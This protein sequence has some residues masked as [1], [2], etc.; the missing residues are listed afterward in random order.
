MDVFFSGQGREE[1]KFALRGGRMNKYEMASPWE[2]RLRK[3]PMLSS[4]E[5]QDCC[6]HCVGT[7]TRAKGETYT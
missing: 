2:P 1:S 4:G 3:L 5:M 6:C 7:T